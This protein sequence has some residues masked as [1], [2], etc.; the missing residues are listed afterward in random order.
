MLLAVLLFITNFM[1]YELVDVQRVQDKRNNVTVNCY[2]KVKC[3]DDDGKSVLQDY[4]LTPEE[5]QSLDSGSLS[6]KEVAEKAAA[7]GKLELSKTSQT[8]LVQHSKEDRDAIAIDPV[9]VDE[10]ITNIQRK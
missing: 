9:K 2:V 8:I 4:F 1:T 3:T 10:I 5:R 7:L 6:I